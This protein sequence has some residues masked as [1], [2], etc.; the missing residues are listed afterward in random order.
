MRIV[1]T[2]SATQANLASNPSTLVS[3]PSADSCQA[4]EQARPASAVA[5]PPAPSSAPTGKRPRF[6]DETLLPSR[7]R[8]LVSP[9]GAAGQPQ[10]RAARVSGSS[11][12]SGASASAVGAQL[13]ITETRQVGSSH[14]PVNKRLRHLPDAERKPSL[15]GDV[16]QGSTTQRRRTNATP[17]VAAPFQMAAGRDAFAASNAVR[18]VGTSP[19]DMSSNGQAQQLAQAIS[20]SLQ[21][22]Q[23][24]ERN[25]VIN[26]STLPVSNAVSESIGA[27]ARYVQ[28]QAQALHHRSLDSAQLKEIQ[29][30]CAAAKEGALRAFQNTFDEKTIHGVHRKVIDAVKNGGR[31]PAQA[32]AAVILESVTPVF[33][34]PDIDEIVNLSVAAMAATAVSA[35][36]QACELSPSSQN[37]ISLYVKDKLNQ[38]VAGQMVV[39]FL[40]DVVRAQAANQPFQ[41]SR[42]TG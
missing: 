41:A 26:F 4:A 21:D 22:I 1:V 13:H 7:A 18:E 8:G 11:M 12:S 2:R 5:P 23:A 14:V 33:A 36:K 40:A 37:D 17:A 32:A 31:S 42:V 6:A 38:L 39:D 10:D 30:R 15:S 28:A 29:S 16:V 19:A 9:G 35:M 27:A 20:Q 24:L 3:N 25:A 34:H